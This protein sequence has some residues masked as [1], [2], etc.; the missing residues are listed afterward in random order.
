MALIRKLATEDIYGPVCDSNVRAPL[1]I[2]VKSVHSFYQ[3]DQVPKPTVGGTP[4]CTYIAVVI[5]ATRPGDD[6]EFKRKVY[7]HCGTYVRCEGQQRPALVA[8]RYATTRKAVP[9]IAYRCNRSEATTCRRNR[10][11]LS[12]GNR[13]ASPKRSW[14]RS[15]GKGSQPTNWGGCT[16]DVKR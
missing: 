16:E 2:I 11:H 5:K 12:G 6:L 10:A 13:K 7:R 4:D 9:V 14:Q 15:D 1:E 8:H 3:Q